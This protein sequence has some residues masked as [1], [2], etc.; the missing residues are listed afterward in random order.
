MDLHGNVSRAALVTPDTPVATLASLLSADAT[1]SRIRL[2]WYSGDAAGAS[3]TVFRSEF[4]SDW[5]SVA[6]V[7]GDGTGVIRYEDHAIVEGH[8]Y[9]YRLG[10][11]IDGVM[12]YAGEVWLTAESPKTQVA[13]AG[14]WPN[15]ASGGRILA[16]FD[17]PSAASASLELWDVAGR[18]IEQHEVGSLGSGHHVAE[19]G[20]GSHLAPGVYLLRLRA[21]TVRLTSRVVLI[22]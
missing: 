18:R 13:L 17:L 14:A 22:E 3:A 7:L 5:Q 16:S 21:G 9:G 12:A 6:Q 4:G 10:L 1:A 20:A 11:M 2:A 19:F 15:P 8:R